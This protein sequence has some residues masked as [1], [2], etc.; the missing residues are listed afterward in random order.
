MLGDYV[1]TQHDI[2]NPAQLHDA[3]AY[4]TWHIDI[5]VSGGMLAPGKE[6]YPPGGRNENWQDLLTMVYGI[7]IRSLYSR[8][9]ENLL[10]AGRPISCSYLAFASTRVLSTGSICG[11]AAGVVAALA[12]K[13]NTIP[14]EIAKSHAP[15][16][17][18]I[19]LRQ[20]GHIPGVENTDE[21][22]LAR[23][24]K[25]TAGNQM[26]MRFPEPN[27]ERELSLPHA[28]L[29]PVSS[30][31][32]DKVEILLR[33]ALTTPATL[34]LGL[35]E[36]PHVWDFRSEED[37]AVAEATVPAG[38]EGW[39][40][41]HLNA[42]VSPGKLYYIYTG[43]QA[44]VFWQSFKETDGAPN[45]VPVGSTPASLPDKTPY[46]EKSVTF[47]EIYSSTQLQDMPGA[48]KNGHWKPLTGG[49]S[50]CTRI[51][52][53]SLPYSAENVIRGTNRPD[54]WSNIWISDPGKGLPASLQLEWE[55]PL[56]FNTVQLTFDT[57]QNRRV[58]LPLFRYPDCV[59]DYA[60][61]Y[62]DGGA[63][64]ELLKEEDNYTRCRV[65]RFDKVHTDKLRVTVLASNGSESARIY[66]MRVYNEDV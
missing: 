11:Q 7:P 22:D 36:A 16:T 35:R 2:Q 48:G 6:P 17:Q 12:K 46:S 57:D 45:L 44:G 37:L 63:W 15:E 47:R 62:Y 9:V 31:R 21:N 49:R 1:L 65:H 25:A 58:T 55:S 28:Q 60:V 52:P 39:V 66:E 29:F 26:R 19:I 54:K 30:G 24:A 50:L 53:E 51:T 13:Y 43:R 23:K 34:R 10:M 56:E 40:S 64:K 27:G 33:S 61:E 14:R 3:V 38:K 20:D 5:H 59:K 4:G 32:V 18:Q 41:F 8:N 42:K